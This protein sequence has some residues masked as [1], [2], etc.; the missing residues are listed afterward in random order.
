MLSKGVPST[1]AN[2]KSL[3]KDNF[4]K[5]TIQDLVEGYASAEWHEEA[6][7]TN[8]SD[9]TSANGDMS[10]FKS[11]A[12]YFL[13]QHYNYHLSRCLE[14]A[15]SHIDKAIE[16]FPTSVDYHMTKARIWKHYGN[17]Q[18]ASE[19]ME[20]A[21]TLDEKDRYINTKAAKYQLRNDENDA[22]LKT[23]SKFTRNETAGGP[24]GDLHE[25]QCM[26]YITEDGE[27]YL[28]QLKLGLSLKRFAA[29][30]EI[31]DVWQEDQF[32]FHSFSLRKG[33]IRAYIDMIRW[34]DRL[35]E[36]PF[37][38]RAAI[39]AVRAYIMLHDKPHL[40]HDSLT[41]G[42]NGNDKDFEKMDSSERKKA[43]KKAKKEQQKQEKADAVKREEKKASTPSTTAD[44]E[45]KRV[46]TD[47]MGTKLAQTTDP[48][49]DAMKFLSPLLEFSPG[50]V[51]AQNV[52]FEVFIRKSK[53][54]YS[55]PSIMSRMT[56]S[57]EKR[58]TSLP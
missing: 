29:I 13:A 24:L 55:L 23:M 43:L 4:K 22:A 51:D 1:F 57:P 48:L 56:N 19:I 58:N 25:M 17:L 40:A 14:K 39:S 37:Y 49:R 33:Q 10:K 38:S 8:G 26:W 2:V 30:Y 16:I 52:G 28:R 12:L 45:P 47:P 42:A 3:Y 27:S 34:E 9:E 6:P 7:Q 20:Y 31:F 21:R 54:S 44:G 53:S 5:C 15:L 41:N 50:N 32:D 18:K 35:R 11:A 36:H 46:D